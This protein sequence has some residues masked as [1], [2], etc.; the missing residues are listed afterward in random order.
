MDKIVLKEKKNGLIKKGSAVYLNRSVQEK[1]K[2][3]ANFYGDFFNKFIS[4]VVG[5]TA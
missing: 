3:I 4:V 5:L 1:C 2:V